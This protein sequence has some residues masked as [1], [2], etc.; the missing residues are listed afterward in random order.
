[1]IHA[2]FATS[3]D[4]T[5]LMQAAS[6]DTISVAA[7]SAIVQIQHLVDEAVHDGAPIKALGNILAQISKQDPGSWGASERSNMDSL[8]NDVENDMTLFL[9]AEHRDDEAD[10]ATAR[11][12]HEQCHSHTQTRFAIGGDVKAEHD[13]LLEWSVKH[14][15]CRKMEKSF[16][17]YRAEAGYCSATSF[18]P[19]TENNE[20]SRLVTKVETLRTDRQ[21]HHEAVPV[22]SSTDC[23]VDQ[24]SYETQFCAWRKSKRFA[25]LSEEDCR[26][27]VGLS[28]FIDRLNRRS[29]NRRKLLVTL[30]KIT[31]RIKHLLTTFDVA[32]NISSVTAD[33]VCDEETVDQVRFQLT[34]SIPTSLECDTDALVSV[35]PSSEPA[36]CT[37]WRAQAYSGSAWSAADHVFPTVCQFACTDDTPTIVTPSDSCTD[38]NAQCAFFRHHQDACDLA[39]YSSGSFVARDECCGCIPVAP[40]APVLTNL[41]M[42]KPVSASS[43]MGGGTVNLACLVDGDLLQGDGEGQSRQIAHTN[44]EMNAWLMVDLEVDVMVSSVVL[45]NGWSYCCMERI[46]PFKIILYRAD[47]TVSAEHGGIVAPVCDNN[48]PCSVTVNMAAPTPAR[49][50]KVQLD[51]HRAFLHPSELQ[52]FGI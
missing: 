9:D 20:H 4:T 14:E 10:F 31:C 41:A 22:G 36:Q 38:T 11:Q 46:N 19:Y 7:S 28:G 25:C 15:K 12:N 30:K 2:A 34:M 35:N 39:M 17:A 29:E 13:H 51:E 26:S 40:P 23:D 33:D 8:L 47:G 18:T 44:S 24:N 16:Q 21:V 1:M 48:G 45:F 52:V 5:D 37:Q 49:S 32:H 42:N 6:Q 50:V 3:G 27:T 43:V